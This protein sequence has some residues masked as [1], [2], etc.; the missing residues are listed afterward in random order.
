MTPTDVI[1]D[2]ALPTPS[3][4]VRLLSRRARKSF[5]QHFLTDRALLDRI[6]SLAGLSPGD[7]VVE[8][9][10][11]PGG[12][13]A[14]LLASGAHVDAIDADGA[15]IEHLRDALG[16]F[17]AL[18]LRHGDATGDALHEVLG[19]PCPPVV[20]NL[21]YNAGTPILF[22]LI[23]RSEPP[24]KMVLM[25]QLEVARR[26]V[27]TG[28]GEDFGPMGLAVGLRYTSRIAFRVPPGAFIPPPRVDSAVVVLDRR[29]SA[30]C[31]PDV[32]DA[33]RMLARTSFGQRRKMLRRSL[34]SVSG[35]VVAL[36]DAADVAPDARPETLDVDAFIRLAMAWISESTRAPR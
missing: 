11:G 16:G 28:P 8:I 22:S 6:V 5:G 33:A 17:P 1:G 21:P 27:A 20:A 23:E 36:C 7:R 32:E 30:L 15:M 14:R 34:A 3:E 2:G 19:A 26:V 10:P 35:D 18:S 24:P 9:G 13:T 25:F 31:E 4:L 29:P 12:L